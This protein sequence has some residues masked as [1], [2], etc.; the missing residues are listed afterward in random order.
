M[1][2]FIY[3]SPDVGKTITRRLSGESTKELVYQI[4]W[5]YFSLGELKNLASQYIDSVVMHTAYPHLKQMYDEYY[6]VLQFLKEWK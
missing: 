6:T 5:Q 3:E 2:N 1:T 4:Q